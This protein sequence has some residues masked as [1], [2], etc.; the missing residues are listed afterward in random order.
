MIDYFTF[1]FSFE[2]VELK[3]L[4]SFPKGCEGT[5]ENKISISDVICSGCKEILFR[6]SV[7]NCGH[8]MFF[9]NSV[10]I[11]AILHSNK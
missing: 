4:D 11:P 6:P 9:K 1:F 3:K 8:G 5:D 7:L 2:N 10:I